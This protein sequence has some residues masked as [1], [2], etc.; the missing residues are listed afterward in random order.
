MAQGRVQAPELQGN[1]ALRPAPIQ[2][3]TYAAPAR[4]ATDNRLASLAQALGAFSNSIGDYA[5]TVKPSKEDRQKAIW[6]AERKMEGMSLEETRKAVDSGALPVFADKWAQQS[7]NAI[8]GGKAGYL[9]ANELKDQMTRDFD[10]D[11]GDPDKHITDA[12]NGYIE[13]SPYKEDPNFGSNFIK[14][15]S[16]LREWSVKFK[17]DR[18]TEQFVETQQQS[19]FDFISTFIDSQSEAGTDPKELTKNLFNQLP[20]LGKAGTL[21]VNEEALEGEVLN[22]ARRIA[23]S[24]PEV[25][26]AIINH[27]RKGRDGMDRSFA[28]DQDKQDVVLQIRA[29]AAKAIGEQFEAS[30]KE[31]IAGYNVELF[32]AGNGDQI[33]DRVIKTPDGREVTLTAEAQRK[34]V[35]AEYDRQS[36]LIAKHRKETPDE[37]MFRELRDYRRQG[38][39]HKGLEQTLTGMAD[40]ASVDMIGDPES[41][42]RLMNKLNVYRKLRQ[43][44][45]NSIM[46]YTKEKDRDFAEAF[47]EATDYLDMSDDAA[48]EFAIKVTQPLDA[49]GREQVSKFQREIDSEIGNL[50]TKKGW[51]GIE[52][53][54]DPTNFS[55]VKTKVSQLAQKMVAAGVKPKEAI[56]MAANAVKANTQSHNGTLLDLNGLDV[57]D[58]FPDAV[59][60]ALVQFIAANPKVIERSGLD[61]EDLTIVPLGGDVS[62]GRFKIVS[63]DNVAV[64]LYN[65]RQE[66]AVLTLAGIRKAWNERKDEDDRG[67][68][69]QDV[70]DHS[71]SQKGLVY[72]VDKDGSKSWIDPK[73]KEKYSFQ[74]TEKDRAPIWK[75]TGQRYGRAIVVK[76]DGGF[77]LKGYE[78]GKFWGRLRGSDLKKY[79]EE[80]KQWGNDIDTAAAKRREWWSKILPSIKVGDTVLND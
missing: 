80:M 58:Q 62:G 66:V 63:K 18:K 34:A 40:M 13:N 25:A 7:A 33:V 10:W 9:F 44:S 32:K 71:A 39:T 8:A 61:P 31:R 21:G 28:G 78:G 60:E 1:V 70:F 35:E 36:K 74:Y 30:E 22:A 46:A 50:S 68:L 52:T 47:V 48:L 59:D 19:A 43:E 17:M 2:S 73:T 72:A 4:P 38:A 53:D 24:H 29:T 15:A 27:T 11:S 26:L 42:D 56:T 41:K 57:P 20:V 67:N 16:A 69:R 64:P 77:V 49:A 14:N 51:F 5:S 45:K 6:A 23:G 37:T 75:K 65:D 54:S 12:I 3:D 76:D 79:R 55:T